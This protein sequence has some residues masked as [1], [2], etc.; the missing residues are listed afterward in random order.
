[1]INLHGPHNYTMTFL[2]TALAILEQW[3]A[4]EQSGLNS[5]TF[6]ACIQSVKA[7][8]ALASYLISTHGGGRVVSASGSET[9]VSSLTPTIAIIY[10]EYTSIIKKKKSKHI[11]LAVL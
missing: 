6:A 1:M 5:E 4:S 10:D 11:A 7:V 3:K 2:K 9:N 8:I